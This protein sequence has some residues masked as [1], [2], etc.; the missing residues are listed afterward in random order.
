MA[1]ADVRFREALAAARAAFDTAQGRLSTLNNE[2]GFLE[3]EI[4]RLRRTIAALSDLCDEPIGL[5]QIG[6]T[7]AVRSVLDQAT[8]QMTTAQVKDGLAELGFDLTTQK[9]PTA[10]VMAVLK[11]LADG[12]EIR[13]QVVGGDPVW[14]G[15]NA[16]VVVENPDDIPF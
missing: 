9:N 6:I 14:L 7:D 10:S 2:V 3:S 1:K 5:E 13:R 11:R 4:V 8:Q 15:K 12:K 16:K